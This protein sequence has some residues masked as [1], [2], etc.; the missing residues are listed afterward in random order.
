MKSYCLFSD[1]LGQFTPQMYEKS[2]LFIVTGC[3]VKTRNVSEIIHNINLVKYKYWGDTKITLHSNKIGRKVNQFKIFNDQKIF[4]EFTDEIC[5]MINNSP[6]NLICVI[7]DQ[8]KSFKKNYTNKTVLK[9]AYG[10]LIS[11][12]VRWLKLKKSTGI[13]I[14]EASSP[15]QDITIYEK[16]FEFQSIGIKSELSHNEVKTRLTSISFST[17]HNQEGL[18]EIADLL[19][20]GVAIDHE[21]KKRKKR[22]KDLNYYENKIRKSM[23]HKMFPNNFGNFQAISY[24]F[25]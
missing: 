9:N 23:K 16:F 22:V 25:E 21:I 6:F 10:R 5:K 14:Q 1:E 3:I 2:P 24:I 11:N 18:T 7:T 20:Y 12:Y 4:K 8:K 13:L 19:G 17:K 15:L